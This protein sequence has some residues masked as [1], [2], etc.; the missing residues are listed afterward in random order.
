MSKGAS[1][2]FSGTKGKQNYNKGFIAKIKL[3]AETKVKSMISNRSGGRSK[4]MA[5]GVYDI[6]T[7]KTTASFAGNIPTKF[8]P[9]IIELANKI[10]G[11]G[12]LGV[13]SKNT[14]GVCAEFHAVNNFLNRGV[15]IANI[16]FTNPIRPRT[17]KPMPF[18]D[19]CRKM[20]SDLI[21][22]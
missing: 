16:R 22:D 18:C 11:I 14:V 4:A 10:G 5:I 2:H 8:H 17:G 6:K 9:V 1:G 7:G 12:S 19:N 15:D 13:T 21:D 20:F 3:N